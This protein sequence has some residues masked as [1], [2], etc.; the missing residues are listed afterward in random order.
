M[1]DARR[2]FDLPS[3]F[4]MK[5]GGALQQARLAYETWGQLNDA[6]SNAILI[7]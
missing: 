1:A 4:P 7:L 2:Y 3:P 6:H 5:R